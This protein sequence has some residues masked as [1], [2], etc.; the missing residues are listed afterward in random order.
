MGSEVSS[1]SPVVVDLI[2]PYVGRKQGAQG[3][4]HPGSAPAWR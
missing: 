3:L 4:Q 2:S 1:P